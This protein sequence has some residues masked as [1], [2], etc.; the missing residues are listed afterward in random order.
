M[1][2]IQV[3]GIS[4]ESASSL[5]DN[6]G[7]RRAKP[8][9]DKRSY[10]QNLSRSDTIFH[11]VHALRLQEVDQLSAIYTSATDIDMAEVDS[12]DDRKAS[13]SPQQH[14]LLTTISNSLVNTA[15]PIRSLPSRA[16]QQSTAM[17]NSRTSALA[18]SERQL[19]SGKQ[20]NTSF[21]SLSEVK[22]SVQAASK[23]Q[24]PLDSVAQDL[25]AEKNRSTGRMLSTSASA[26]I[27]TN[28]QIRSRIKI[29]DEVDMSSSTKRQDS[30]S[31]REGYY[32][33]LVSGRSQLRSKTTADTNDASSAKDKTPAFSPPTFLPQPVTK[34]FK[35]SVVDIQPEKVKNFSSTPLQ[36]LS[37]QDPKTN[38]ASNSLSAPLG[39]SK[40]RTAGHSQL[41]ESSQVVA[42]YQPRQ[43]I[44][45][46]T[47][48]DVYA[49]Q[50][51]ENSPGSIKQPKDSGA[52]ANNLS[53]GKSSGSSS[54]IPSAPPQQLKPQGSRPTSASTAKRKASDTKDNPHVLQWPNNVSAQLHAL[55]VRKDSV[56]PEALPEKP[57]GRK[58]A[59]DDVG[60]LSHIKPDS[61][62]S[63]PPPER[64]KKP[65]LTA[66]QMRRRSNRAKNSRIPPNKQKKQK[67]Q[68][69][70]PQIADNSSLSNPLLSQST[71][72]IFGSQSQT[73]SAVDEFMKV[74][75]QDSDLG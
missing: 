38:N 9:V 51:L 10:H 30:L 31:A 15:R 41:A 54:A 66:A 62:C 37:H 11:N 1:L 34:T 32:L 53:P 74:I 6:E 64:A 46:Q 57:S 68:T 21:V 67:T 70:A 43:P 29:I 14:N 2:Q 17:T 58:A 55:P 49:S 69:P 28:H 4:S 63:S 19:R 25:C 50:I 8:T 35:K 39:K 40:S 52:W 24:P 36:N 75:C 13:P 61:S 20:S 71:S 45:S 72:D 5:K 23:N 47:V 12:H 3:L 42:S 18:P 33:K 48:S 27:N 73:R 16:Q 44:I 26:S 59:A 65:R 22:S 60:S 56:S 7:P